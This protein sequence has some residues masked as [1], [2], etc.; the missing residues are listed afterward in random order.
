MR[1]LISEYV[2]TE[3]DKQ[4]LDSLKDSIWGNIQSKSMIAPGI[5]TVSTPSHGGFVLSD[6][7]VDQ[8]PPS[9][10]RESYY[11]EDCEWA[12]VVAAFPE[13]FGLR[14]RRDA[15]LALKSQ[16]EVEFVKAH[17]E[18]CYNFNQLRDDAGVFR[19]EFGENFTT[20]TF[21]SGGL[22][23][24]ITQQYRRISDRAELV[25]RFP[26]KYDVYDMPRDK[27]E[28]ISREAIE[29]IEGIEILEAPPITPSV[30]ID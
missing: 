12:Q 15:F 7:K 3:A 21:M 22:S 24:Q 30:D 11:E 14:T 27:G 29:S 8:L 1:K 2:P 23:G 4:F 6:E 5:A 13:D 25:A 9:Y 26:P 19:A 16:G 18:V 17:P 28:G 10:N 20:S